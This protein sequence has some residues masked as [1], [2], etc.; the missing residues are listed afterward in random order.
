MGERRAGSAGSSD[1]E[2]RD[3]SSKRGK[4]ET[5]VGP[6]RPE[7]L[8]N[9]QQKMLAMAGQDIDDFMKEVRGVILRG[10]NLVV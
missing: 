9:V 4:G 3:R 1:D 6:V 8:S 10:G 2:D 5:G 7:G